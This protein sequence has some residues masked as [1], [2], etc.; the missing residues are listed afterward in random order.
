M[1]GEGGRKK[2]A[3]KREEETQQVEKK[4]VRGRGEG[5]KLKE[6]KEKGFPPTST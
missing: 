5:G 4:C 6:N 2:R 3:R 1:D